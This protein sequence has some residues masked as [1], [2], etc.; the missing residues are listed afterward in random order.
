LQVNADRSVGL[1]LAPKPPSGKESIRL[2]TRAD[3]RFYAC[4]RFHG[5]TEA[6]ANRAWELADF[7][8]AK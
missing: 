5:A 2:A 7:Q 6:L 1:Y 4:A 8:V 3:G